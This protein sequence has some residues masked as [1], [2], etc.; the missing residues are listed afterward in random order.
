MS[1]RKIFVP[2][3]IDQKNELDRACAM[4]SAL[5]VLVSAPTAVSWLAAGAGVPTFKLLYDMSWTALGQ[6]HEP[7]APACHC[8]MPESRGDWADVFAQAAAIIRAALSGVRAAASAWARS[9]AMRAA[10]CPSISDKPACAHVA[11]RAP[12]CSSAIARCARYLSSLTSI[13]HAQRNAHA[14]IGKG[15]GG[16]RHGRAVR[17]R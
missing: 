15:A 2:P 13:G 6:T 12:A 8:V 9:A 4:L 14:G 7:F 16:T 11:P 3:G 10:P 5:D 1:G 17:P